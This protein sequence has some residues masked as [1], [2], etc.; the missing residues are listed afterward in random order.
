[1]KS[2]VRFGLLIAALVSFLLGCA[3]ISVTVL[4]VFNQVQSSFSDGSFEDFQGP[5]KV[6]QVIST[7]APVTGALLLAVSVAC[8]VGAIASWVVTESVD[9]AALHRAA[10]AATPAPAAVAGPSH[11]S[12][13]ETLGDA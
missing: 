5:S 2:R 1:M 7:L 11:L 9:R 4:G 12:T 8:V 13:P 10:P 3:A 6:D